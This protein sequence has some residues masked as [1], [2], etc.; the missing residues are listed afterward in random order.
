ME[1]PVHEHIIPD[2]NKEE[3]IDIS[4]GSFVNTM[5]REI[6]ISVPLDFFFLKQKLKV[7]NK[8][9]LWPRKYKLLVSSKMFGIKTHFILEL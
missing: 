5:L 2:S 7:R 6:T 1:R 8:D 3:M 9:L 4:L